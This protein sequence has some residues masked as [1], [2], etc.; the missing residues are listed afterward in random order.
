MAD[1]SRC[2]A[3]R[4]IYGDIGCKGL[5]SGLPIRILIIGTLMGSSMADL[6]YFQGNACLPTTGRHREDLVRS[7]D[8]VMTSSGWG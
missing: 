3:M 5:W 1:E 8:G 2:K 6:R 7:F 4:R